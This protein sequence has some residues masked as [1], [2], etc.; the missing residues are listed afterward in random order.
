MG[1]STIAEQF[2][3]NEY[4]SYIFIDFTK[5]SRDIKALFDD[6][7]DLDYIFNRLQLAFGKTLVQRKSV[8]VFDEVQD[9]PKA[10]QAIKH[11]VADRRYDY[12]ET[13]SLISIRQN[14]KNI[15]IPSE[16]QEIKMFPLDYE[17]FR[18]AM[19]DVATIPLLRQVY[20][21][22]QPLGDGINRKLM[23]DFRLYMLVGGMPQAVSKYLSTKSLSETDKTKRTIISLY[24]KDFMRIDPSGRASEMFKAIPAQLNK[25]SSRYQVS[26][27]TEHGRA[28]RLAETLFNMT[29]SMVVN[30]SY[31]ANDP[32][33]GMAFHR[34]TAA[35]KM[36][37]GDTG[38][39]VTLA[40]WDKDFTENIIYQKL[41]TDKLSK[42]LGY[43]YENV[44]AQI[45]KS[46][47]IE[48]YYYTFPTE[49]RKHNYEIDFLL[50]D[51]DKVNPI[52][53]KS[54]NYK[55]H[56]SL[57]AFFNKFHSRIREQYVVYTKDLR[58]DNMITY[59]PVYMTALLGNNKE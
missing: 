14:I 10:R 54:S 34:D 17:E 46:S 30:M 47:G 53:V 31:R 59:L 35:F 37:L 57:D 49:S 43:V 4:D 29:E 41:L 50:P 32:G 12:I 58:K 56:A 36:F 23:R 44:V 3:K 33:P 38:L 8:I 42:D 20:Q 55:T 15:L 21:K 22:K 2:A 24:D 28:D 18:W 27:A 5:C 39:F 9:C 52:E 6:I 40:F 26:S 48:L 11:L 7:S 19:G 16:E 13:G 45:L 51:G 1:K 25:N